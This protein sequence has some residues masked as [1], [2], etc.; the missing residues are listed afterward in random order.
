MSCLKEY[1]NSAKAVGRNAR[2]IQTVIISSLLDS[3][4]CIFLHYRLPADMQKV[5]CEYL[6]KIL[7]RLCD[8]GRMDF[9]VRDNNVRE[10]L[11]S[12]TLGKVRGYA[13]ERHVRSQANILCRFLQPLLV[14]LDIGSTS[15]LLK[16]QN[17]QVI[18]DSLA[19]FGGI[20]DFFDNPETFLETWKA[21]EV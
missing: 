18:F 9:C 7:A 1:G 20:Q 12:Q 16:I 4:L 5:H 11:L 13:L 3:F 10:Y 8:P 21:K 2:T 19:E 15:E 6:T 14:K 17:A